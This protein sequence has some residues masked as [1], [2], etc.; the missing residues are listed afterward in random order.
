V[1][2]PLLGSLFGGT[3]QCMLCKNG[4]IMIVWS[5]NW[6]SY[7]LGKSKPVS[8]WNCTMLPLFCAVRD[9]CNGLISFW[10]NWHVL[11][12]FMVLFCHIFLFISH[13][14]IITE[15]GSKTITWWLFFKD[16]HMP[17]NLYPLLL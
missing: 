12:R 1:R 13:V 2:L 10:A 15:T 6:D 9:I 4:Q 14:I 5:W 8:L 11:C 16:H 17:C 3:V 7:L